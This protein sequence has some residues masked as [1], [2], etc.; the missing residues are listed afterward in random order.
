[1]SFVSTTPL[2]VFVCSGDLSDVYLKL[3]YSSIGLVLS[4]LLLWRG[5]KENKL[6]PD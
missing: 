3:V 4:G 6:K 1:M 5:N 2:N